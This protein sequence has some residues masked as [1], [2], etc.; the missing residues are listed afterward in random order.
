[1]ESSN[2]C[3]VAFLDILGFKQLVQSARHEDL[4]KLYSNLFVTNAAMAVTNGAYKVVDSIASQQ[5]AL[6]DFANAKID[7][8]V[9]SDSV[10]MYTK[11][12]SIQSLLDLSV[13]AGKLTMMGF[14]TGLPMR[15]TIARGPLSAFK[16][17]ESD[18]EFAVYGLVGLALVKAYSNESTYDWAGCVVDSECIERYEQLHGIAQSQGA[19][20]P[21]ISDVVDHGILIKYHTPTKDLPPS[22]QWVINWPRFNRSPINPQ[23]IQRSF[24]QHGKSAQHESVQCK[25]RNTLDFLAYSNSQ[26]QA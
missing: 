7:C 4:H 20:A 24:E 11:D 1:M 26:R 15:G 16:R 8:M 9:I 23:V 17:Q 12:D 5:I 3:Y 19:Q 14:Y 10:L 2:H 18:A 22:E 25:L 21:T 13:S 6:P